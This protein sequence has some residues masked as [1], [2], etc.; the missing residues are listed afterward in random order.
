[1]RFRAFVASLLVVLTASLLLAAAGSSAP[2]AAGIDPGLSRFYSQKLVWTACGAGFD[3]A[4]VRV[5]VDY[6]RPA[7]ATTRIALKRLKSS[8]GSKRLGT[9]FF[10]PGG[11]GGSGVSLMRDIGAAL[12]GGLGGS[13]D[14]VGVDP[15]GV[16]AS[17]PIDCLSDP[18][19]D[20]WWGRPAAPTTPAEKKAYLSAITVFGKG[21][22]RRSG[23]LAAHVSTVEVAKDLD[24]MRALV[25]DKKLT[26]LG[27]SYGT[28]IGA[29]Y[30]QLFPKVVGRMVLDGA[31]DPKLNG[32]DAQRSQLRGYQGVLTAFVRD[33]VTLPDCPLGTTEAG[34]TTT[35]ATFVGGLAKKPLPTGDPKRPLSDARALYAMISKLGSPGGW[36]ELRTALAAGLQGD[37][38][39]LSSLADTFL[40]RQADGS[41][42]NK[43]NEFEVNKA[44]VCLDSASR[45]GPTVA[46]RILPGFKA[47]SPLFGP[48][49]AWD[50]ATCETWP[51]PAT[52]PRP[53]IRPTGVPP[54]LVVGTT[55][56]NATPYSQAVALSKALP[57]AR[58]LTY[59]GDGHL[60]YL[61]RGSSCIDDAV[62]NYFKTGALP[63]KGTRC[64]A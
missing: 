34:A 48:L 9:L 36:E 19:T 45:G 30:A 50:A 10:D 12:N 25:G 3:C 31:E 17:A 52:N 63:P 2:R 21:C 59:V 35:L 38:G 15:R 13:Y 26:Y 7:G 32:A 29:V 27:W 37:G 64:T 49:F 16:G 40:G 5:P 55:N 39:K 6:A 1:M 11:P 42:L 44:V 54:I 57:N 62:N 28:K 56:D 23:Q 8:D 18:Q 14:I 4:R 20:A 22:L 46:Q 51:L 47:I 60:A 33:C 61:I 53:V 41:Y 24:I 43:G 58:L